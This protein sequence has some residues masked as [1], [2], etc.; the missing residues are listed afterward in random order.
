MVYLSQPGTIN[1][2]VR[3]MN[4]QVVKQGADKQLS[5]GNHMISM[6]C[7]N[8]PSGIYTYTLVAGGSSV[9]KKMIID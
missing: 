6:N 4:G 5:R 7:S 8:L 3:N 9:S 1:L 2:T